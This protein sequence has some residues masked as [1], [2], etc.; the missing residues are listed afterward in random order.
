[1]RFQKMRTTNIVQKS[2]SSREV[3]ENAIAMTIDE[4]SSVFLMDALGKLYSRPAQAVLREYLSNA[5]DAHKAKGGKLPAIQITLPEASNRADSSR[6]YIRDF[7]KGMNEEEFGSI[8]SRYGASTKRDSNAMIGGFGLGAKSGFA[9]SDEFFMTSYQQG[10]GLRVRIFKDNLNQGYIDVIDRFSTKE[11]DG[12]LVEVPIPNGNIP[13]LSK[14]ALFTDFPFFMGYGADAIDVRPAA[15]Y[16][17]QS[18]YNKKAFAPLELAGNTIGW[19]GNKSEGPSKMYALVGKVAYSIDMSKLLVSTKQNKNSDK[20]FAATLANLMT[21]RR[22]KVLDVPIGSVDMPSA[23]EEIT[24]SERSYKTLSAVMSNYAMI[25]K[26]HIQKELNTKTTKLQVVKFLAEL[27][28]D[29]YKDIAGLS[30]KGQTFDADF[31]KKSEAIL[32]TYNKSAYGD[33]SISSDPI[34]KGYDFR[35]FRHLSDKSEYSLGI[36]RITVDSAADIPA[37]K[38]LLTTKTITGFFNIA[39]SSSTGSR[40]YRQAQKA[41]FIIIP[42]DDVLSTWLF[43]HTPLEVSA[44]EYVVESARLAKEAEAEKAK[45]E[46]LKQEAAREKARKAKETRAQSMLSNFIV[47]DS[48]SRSVTRNTVENVFKNDGVKRYYWSEEEVNAFLNVSKNVTKIGNVRERTHLLFPF[49]A[50]PIANTFNPVKERQNYSEIN[51]LVKLRSFLRL[52]FDQG[53]KMI[54]LGKAWDLDE[55]KTTYPTV[56]SGVLAVKEAIDSQLADEHSAIMIAYNSIGDARWK[57]KSEVKNLLRFVEEL[58]D[59]QRTELNEELTSAVERFNVVMSSSSIN[60]LDDKY[61]MDVLK[62]FATMAAI[63]EKSYSV[64]NDTTA[65]TEKYPLL[66]KGNFRGSSGIYGPNVVSHL[67]EYIKM[68]DAKK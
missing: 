53:T 7:G 16:A 5:V 48:G 22:V 34:A 27:Q 4:A 26:Q 63:K 51:Y 32:T 36:Q 6:L 12:I 13:E 61:F 58:N 43:N 59:E 28:A 25:L 41:L 62:C 15:D 17:G 2:Q 65:L 3:G 60:G 19:L 35:G 24:Y 30:W 23:R 20:E 31:F 52:F 14:K 42:K 49:I 46:K 55:F 39:K 18:V 37:V 64:A 56:E 66:M 11:A 21:F 29:G 40:S 9:L 50:T 38:K 10:R 1:M 33:D 8:L 44:L 57:D 68:C 45:Q 67:L 47:N 54:V